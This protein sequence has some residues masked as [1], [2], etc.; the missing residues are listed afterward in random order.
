MNDARQMKKFKEYVQTIIRVDKFVELS[1][2]NQM[3]Q[4]WNELDINFKLHVQ[5]STSTINLNDFFKDLKKRK[6][7]W[8]KL[9][10][11]RVV[12]ELFRQFD[13]QI[14]QRKN[15]NQNQNEENQ[16]RDTS[17]VNYNNRNREQQVDEY[18]STNNAFRFEFQST[19]VSI[20]FQN[21]IL[22]N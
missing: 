5:R 20:Q 17:N 15:D 4:I 13:Y 7:F 10:E 19:Y 12:H 9:I 8:W 1:I 11:N 3:L 2:Y 22:S 14:D 6:N 16:Q 18:I 21:F